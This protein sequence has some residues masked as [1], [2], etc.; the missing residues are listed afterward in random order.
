MIEWASR[1][2]IA[3]LLLGTALQFFASSDSILAQAVDK[4]VD[5]V[6][7]NGQVVTVDDDFSVAEA[8]AIDEGRILAVGKNETIN[9]HIGSGTRV[10]DLHG[11]MVLPGLIE[12]HCHAI[13]VGNSALEQPYVEL[14]TISDVQAWIRKRADEVPKGR[15][16]RV[17]RTDITRL[18][19]RRHPT[20]AELDAATTTH[21]VI[22]NAA[23]KNVLNSLGFELVGVKN[24]PQTAPPELEGRVRRDK[25]GKPVMIIGGDSYLRKFATAREYS[26]EETLSA[27]RRVHRRYNEVGITSIFERASN[28]EGVDVYR[29]L[30]DA[31]ELTVRT[32]LT[33]RQQFRSG[34]AVGPFSESLGLKTGDGDDWVRIGPLKITVDGGIHWGNTYLRE[35]YGDKRV[36]FYA[37]DDPQYRGDISYST[38]LLKDVFS[39][40]HQ[41]GWQMC[42]HVTGDAGVDRVLEALAAVDRETPINDRRFTMT[43]AYFPAID[44]I[45]RARG[46]GVCVDTQPYLYLKDAEAMA[47]VYG[48]EWA[49]RFIGLGDWVAGGIP[50]AINSDHMIGLDPDHAMNSFN[51]FLMMW[52]AVAR[53]T[54]QGNIYGE[55]QRLSREDALRCVTRHAAY[56][57][58]DE[59]RKGSL[60][61]GKLA[62]LVIIDR[63]YLTCSEEEIRQIR[64]L[65]TMVDGEFVY[66]AEEWSLSN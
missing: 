30:R 52:I 22:F 58:F 25:S 39:A 28:R 16:L 38:A 34:D 24:D 6:L 13:G 32:T 15:W 17:P 18:V 56:L 54:D 2:W 7:R 20:P 12:T 57:S 45:E 14:K 10:L 26:E 3:C 9:R 41:L 62:D 19:E 60:E 21:P 5:V 44:S 59:D 27:L 65:A 46:L 8:V 37:L 66:T 23:R 42:C 43:H 40:G 31:D 35:E 53:R 63:D 4:K 51:P 55:R 47:E 33:I 29:K 64:P 49:E 50:L 11:K 1:R 48:T 61:A 36:A